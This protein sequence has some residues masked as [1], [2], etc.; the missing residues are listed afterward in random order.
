MTLLSPIYFTTHEDAVADEVCPTKLWYKRYEGGNGISLRTDLLKN[1]MIDATRADLRM[2]SQMEDISKSAI[3][4]TINEIL[5][6]IPYDMQGD[7][8]AKELLYRRLGWFAAQA[9]FIEPALRKI[10]DTLPIPEEMDLERR[11]LILR[12]Q[13][14]RLLRNKH[15]F[16]VEHRGYMP[17]PVATLR[18]REKWQWD[19]LPQLHLLTAREGTDWKVGTARIQGL[20]IGITPNTPNAQL[21]HPYVY[22]YF[23]RTTGEWTHKYHGIEEAG[24]SWVERPIWDSPLNITTWVHKCGAQVADA[25]FPLSDRLA[26]NAG[27]SQRWLD[28]RFY[29]ERNLAQLKPALRDPSMVISKAVNFPPNTTACAPL[30]EPHCAF[31]DVCWAESFMKD[32]L[33]KSSSFVPNLPLLLT[34]QVKEEKPIVVSP[35]PTLSQLVEES[36]SAASLQIKQGEIIDLRPTPVTTFDYSTLN[37]TTQALGPGAPS[38]TV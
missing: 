25:Q 29:R 30:H 27:M 16:Q 18:W 9:L 21:H 7:L 14:G 22:A 4:D 37:N 20:N 3:Q 13:M 33:L 28:R 24:G 34:Q 19:I 15:T 31:K 12:M 8:Q 35:R 32:A 26:F 6:S 23:N 5:V 10:Y 1:A 38:G 2:L 17:S 36:M 11:P